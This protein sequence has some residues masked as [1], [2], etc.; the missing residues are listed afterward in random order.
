MEVA[1]SVGATIRPMP[2]T[3]QSAVSYR[4]GTTLS[5]LSPLIDASEAMPPH[6]R[7]RTMPHTTSMTRQRVDLTR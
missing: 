4:E 7:T 2:R 5:T 6:R 3:K 1:D